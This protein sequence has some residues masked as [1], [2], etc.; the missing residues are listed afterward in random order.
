MELQPSAE[1][2]STRAYLCAVRREILILIQWM[3][4]YYRHALCSPSIQAANTPKDMQGADRSLGR[5][6]VVRMNG[7]YGQTC[8]R[9]WY[10]F[11]PLPSLLEDGDNRRS[12]STGLLRSAK[13]VMLR[14][15]LPPALVLLLLY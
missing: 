15:A 7:Q 1:L 10:H 3:S 5:Y 13:A 9:V 2:A 6:R 8:F 4:C 12:N 11:T 14:N